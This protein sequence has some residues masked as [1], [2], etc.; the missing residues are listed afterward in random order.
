MDFLETLTLHFRIAKLQFVDRNIS[1]TLTSFTDNI[2]K[3]SK[4]EFNQ[5]FQDANNNTKASTI[6]PFF[7]PHPRYPIF[8][9][10]VGV[11]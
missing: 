10:K 4:Q 2:K 5:S 1:K 6:P 11:R 7:T 3:I 8:S 9:D